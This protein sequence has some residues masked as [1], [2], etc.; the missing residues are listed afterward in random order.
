MLFHSKDGNGV[1]D[2]F[3]LP[4]CASDMERLTSFNQSQNGSVLNTTCYWTEFQACE[5]NRSCAMFP[6]QFPHTKR[7]RECGPAAHIEGIG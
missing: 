3:S 7:I 4:T 5:T 2:A 1:L 6:I